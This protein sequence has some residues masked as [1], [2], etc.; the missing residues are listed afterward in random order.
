MLMLIYCK[1]KI[2]KSLLLIL[3]TLK[4]HNYLELNEF[5]KNNKV[6]FKE[7]IIIRKMNNR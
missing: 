2:K 4:V 3:I 1:C 6:K 7:Q 5:I